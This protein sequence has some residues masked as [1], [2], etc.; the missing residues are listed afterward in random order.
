MGFDQ[1]T[2]VHLCSNSADVDD[3]GNWQW[4]LN[5]VVQPPTE[6]YKL[7][8]RLEQFSCRADVVSIDK[9]SSL[10]VNLFTR[11]T[12]IVPWRTATIAYSF[13]VFYDLDSIIARLAAVVDGDKFF[14]FTYDALTNRFS[15]EINN[16][17]DGAPAPLSK[18]TIVLDEDD[19]NVSHLWRILGFK[20]SITFVKVPNSVLA[21]KWGLPTQ[22]DYAPD[23]IGTRFIIK[24]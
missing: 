3:N 19:P 9:Y 16:A 17:A 7:A 24:C 1:T 15:V 13:P 22:A 10:T 20:Q 4:N 21:N 12:D 5:T 8:V 18:I 23:L 14:L 2:V 11:A 6:A